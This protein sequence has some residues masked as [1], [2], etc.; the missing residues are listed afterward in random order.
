[1]EEYK[2][3]PFFDG[4]AKLKIFAVSALL[5]TAVNLIHIKYLVFHCQ[6]FRLKSFSLWLD[7]QLLLT[8][9]NIHV[10]GLFQHLG[11]CMTSK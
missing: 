8:L 11:I 1:M 10:I 6:I 9:R 2:S 7:C 5:I 4:F 3:V